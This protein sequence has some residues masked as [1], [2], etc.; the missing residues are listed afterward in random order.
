MMT[1]VQKTLLRQVALSWVG[2]PF[3]LN[4]AFRGRHGGV[5]CKL[6]VVAILAEHFGGPSVDITEFMRD[7]RPFVDDGGMRSSFLRLFEGR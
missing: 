1:L 3:R 7:E 2:T 5:D 6:L 4:C